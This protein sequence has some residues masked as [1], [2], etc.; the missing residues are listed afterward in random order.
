MPKKSLERKLSSGLFF[1]DGAMGTQLMAR[2]IG[3]GK[4][5]EMLNIE[6]PDIILDIHRLYFEAGSDAVYTNT[7]GA[8][9]ITL[10]RHGLA[11]KVEQINAAGVKIAKQAAS[12]DKFVLGDIGPCGDFLKP[13]G[14]LEPEKL[15]NAFARQAKTLCDAEADGFIIETMTAVDEA[16]IAVEAVKSVCS[17]PVFVSFAFDAARDDFRTMM[18][19]S[20]ETIVGEISALG[21]NG[22]GFNCGTLKMERY[23]ALTEKFAKLLAGTN[24]LLVAKPNAGKPE[25]LDDRAVYS[26]SGRDFALWLEKIH[27]AGAAIL[28][29]CCGTGP[30]HIK[31]MCG[32]LKR[33]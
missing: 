5:N 14:N 32:K 3:A 1:L 21:V 20:V 33:V 15:K 11:D 28:G 12:G 29:G 18:G 31:A 10:A 19:A 2:G 22:I 7:F 6:S 16:K 9:E 23:F 30:E 13:L 25:L 8:N 24:V 4:C 27:K 17:L 26:L